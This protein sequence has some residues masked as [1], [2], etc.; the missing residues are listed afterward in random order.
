MIFTAMVR[1]IIL[2]AFN[3]ADARLEGVS[4][5]GSAYT[6]GSTG[7]TDIKLYLDANWTPPFNIGGA[8]LIITELSDLQYSGG[9]ILGDSSLPYGHI[10]DGS[11]NPVL[12][13]GNYTYYYALFDGDTTTLTAYH[14]YTSI[15]GVYT[16]KQYAL[17]GA[18]GTDGSQVG[19]SDFDPGSVTSTTYFIHLAVPLLNTPGA[20]VKF[21]IFKQSESGNPSINDNAIDLR[22]YISNISWSTSI[23]RGYDTATVE[24]NESASSLGQF[25]SYM[26]NQNIDIIDIYG[27]RCWNGVITN[28]YFD[29]AGG[30]IDAVGYKRTMEWFRFDRI[31]PAPE[32]GFDVDNRGPTS[33]QILHDVTLANPY[34][35][36]FFLDLNSPQ[37][38]GTNWGV[39]GFV[40]GSGYNDS[41]VYD[42]D[43]SWPRAQHIATSYVGLNEIDFSDG[44]FK[45]SD[46][47]D[48][49]ESFGY[50][51]T[52]EGTFSADTVY[53][54]CWAD[55][56]A[57]VKRV[58]KDAS[59]IE[60]EYYITGRNVRNGGGGVEISGD[61][62]EII[63][64]VYVVYNSDDGESLVSSSIYNL[65]LIR[66]YGDR[67]AIK[68]SDF[69]PGLASLIS[70]AA[71]SDK[72]VIL[73][74]G[75]VEISGNVKGGGGSMQN[76][77]CY[78]LKAGSIIAFEDNIGYG[79]LYKNKN[80]TPGVF[81]IGST[82]FS[83]SSGTITISPAV[84][85][86]AVELFIKRQSALT[87]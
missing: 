86:S 47:V 49:V 58:K 41:N 87:N 80:G 19:T 6:V 79:S 12:T 83:T 43:K 59:T 21:V 7:T 75:N 82:S 34:M 67:L 18:D 44:S 22:K 1:E 65:D 35:K 69:G 40:D 66:Q 60:P 70:Q 84:T 13:N 37:T 29:G 39:K 16:D 48:T 9:L 81:Y 85:L 53:L 32:A 76:V 63:T 54:Q 57:R 33:S 71:R 46:A 20:G 42:P 72:S 27:N 62:S 45:C 23:D 15:F 73:G 61:I 55:G 25:Y 52:N 24:L 5:K 17:D 4:D 50:A 26:L 8:N 10:V 68:T 2:S 51:Y 28:I 36:K 56:Y 77:P 74:V 11:N 14:T 64:E 3:F 78:Q 38:T 31:Y 30:R